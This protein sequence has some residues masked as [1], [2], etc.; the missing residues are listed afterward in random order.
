VRF[1]LA[2]LVLVTGLVVSS[3]GRAQQ[4]VFDGAPIAD[5]EVVG[6]QRIEADTI[7]S[8]MQLGPNDRFEPAAIDRAF[9]SVFGTGLFADVAF[10]RRGNVLIVE[11]VENPVINR[12]VFEGNDD[13][14]AEILQQEIQLRPRVVYT[15]TRVQSDTQ[16]IIDIYRRS[17]RYNV[18]VEPKI[19]KLDQNRVD[20]IFEINENETTLVE[21]IDFVGNEAYSDGSLRDELLTKEAAFWRF[22]TT[23]DVYDPDRLAV[24]QEALRRFY[25]EEGYAD[26]RV[27]SAVAELSPDQTAFFITFTVEEGVRY[28]IGTVE[29]VSTLPDLDPEEL[30]SELEVEE[31]DWFDISEID[32]SVDNLVSTIG[33][34]GYAFVDVRPRY[35]RDPE[36]AVINL[37]FEIQEGPRVFVDRIEI[38]GNVRTLDKVIRREFRLI[39]G[40]PF[41]AARLERTQQRI[42]NLGYF[43]FVRIEPVP[44]AD[45]DKVRIEVEVEEQSTGELT[46]GIGFSTAEGPLGTI[47]LRERNLLGR[48]QDLRF[49]VS[50]SGRRSQINLAFTD[51][52]FRDLPLAAGFDVYRTETDRD[53]S[54]FNEERIGLGLRAGYELTEYTRQSWRYTLEHSDVFDVSDSASQA[55]MQQAG[56]TLTSAIQHSIVYDRRDNRIFPHEG[57]YFSISSELAGLGGDV[58]NFATSV[59]AGY[60]IPFGDSVTLELTAEA[61][62][63]QGIGQDVRITDAYFVGGANL[64]GFADGGIGP[65]DTDTGDFLGGNMFALGSVQLSFPLGLPEEYGIG[66]RVFTDFGTLTDTDAT[67][68]DPLT[69]NI[70]DSGSLRASVGAGITWNSFLGPIAVDLAWPIA[71]E[72]YDEEEFFRFSVGARF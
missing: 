29:L 9:K 46:F 62:R 7:R 23:S 24:D 72:A 39:E 14:D 55:V 66:G 2:I 25:N 34:L 56:V 53:E 50:L 13:I 37:I 6:N 1:V 21:R 31:G 68:T 19:I 59:A 47:G 28:Q 71:K 12:L 60:Y 44:T 26:F 65:Q 42:Q 17:G 38:I 57:H 30:Y 54:S 27:V 61:G 33:T 8:Y 49:D 70:E 22:L 20:L 40:D 4:F 32:K 67:C 45:A 11:V 36:N 3:P 43:S 5:V 64:R 10:D 52:Y 69:C 18:T 51:P 48:G 16:R 63:I 58:R 15:Q 41:N 35:D